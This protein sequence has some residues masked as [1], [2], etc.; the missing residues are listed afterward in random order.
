MLRHPRRSRYP[1]IWEMACRIIID[2]G[3]MI[4]GGHCCSVNLAPLQ[5]KILRRFGAIPTL[6]SYDRWMT[7][8]KG[9]LFVSI[10]DRTAA[11]RISN[12]LLARLAGAQTLKMGR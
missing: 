4:V 9:C 5:G 2:F 1:T 11:A 7:V 3:R 12:S 8:Q 6:A 10:W